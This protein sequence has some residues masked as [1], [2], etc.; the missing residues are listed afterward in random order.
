MVTNGTEERKASI[1]LECRVQRQCSVLR[2]CSASGYGQK[3][4]EVRRRE[5]MHGDRSKQLWLT[6]IQI[7]YINFKETTFEG[8]IWASVE[9]GD[10]LGMLIWLET[11]N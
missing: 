2:E 5:Q 3:E 6:G 7:L 10:T 8:A 4:V 1:K 11:I 9:L